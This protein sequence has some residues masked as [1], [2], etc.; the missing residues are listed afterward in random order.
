[1]KKLFFSLLLTVLC[2]AG[3][4]AQ[5]VTSEPPII[6][7]S[8]TGIVLT[9][10]PDSPES[11]Q[12]LANL[13]ASE[14][15]YAHI[16]LI[17]D[18]STGLSDWKYATTWL[19]NSDKYKLTYVSANTYTLA[20]GDLHSY[21]TA[22][23]AGEKVQKIALV[24]RNATASK[25]G[26]TASGG[27]IFVDVYDDGF[28]MA[29][30]STVSDGV[31]QVGS[32]ANFTVAATESSTL[33][34][35]ING[36][37]V[38]TAS[39]VTQLKYTHNFTAGGT[40][41]F[42]ATATNAAGTTL[43]KSMTVTAPDP[44]AQVDYPGGVPH[45]GPVANADGSVTFCLA[46]PEKSQVILVPS[47]DDYAV[48]DKNVMAYQDYEGYRYFWITVKGLDPATPYPYY[49]LVDGKTKV[50]DPYARLVLDPYNDKYISSTVWPERP[51]Y[52]YDRFSDVMLAV[53]QGN[54]ENDFKFSDFTIPDHHSLVIY[55]M[56]FRD[57]TGTEGRANANGTVRAAIE[58][59]PYLV[60][61]GVNAVELMPIMEFNGNNS[62]GYNTNFYFAPDKAYGSPR[63]YK[64]F[65]E[66]CHRNGIAVILDIVFNQSD[67][68]HPWYQMYNIASN[69]FYN[70]VAPH[71]YSVLNDWKQDNPLVQQQW[72]DALRYW[73]TV[74]N[75]DGFRF[76]LVKGLG[77]N[78]SYGGGTE[79]LNRSRIERMKHLHAVISSVKA[80]GIHINENLAGASEETQMGNDGQLQWA[81]FSNNSIQFAIGESE[82]GN[83]GRLNQ[84]YKNYGRPSG[85][86]IAYAESH[87]EERVGY[88]ISKNAP[89]G[90]RNSTYASR[91]LAMLA[92][93]FLLTPGPK[94]IWQFGELGANQTT[95]NSNGGNNTSP[96]RVIWSN[97]D[98]PDYAALHDAYRTML[99][100]RRDNPE[101]FDASTTYTIRNL[102]GSMT[103][104]RSI[105]LCNG[106]KEVVAFINANTSGD[107][108]EFS[109]ATSLL[110]ESNAQLLYA[111]PD[112]TPTLTGSGTVNVTLPANSMAIY[113]TK[114]V[115][116]NDDV[117]ADDVAAP[118]VTVR[119]GAGCI[120][121][122][123]EYTE[124]AA[125]TLD[126]RSVSTLDNLTAGIYI[127]RV[128]N[129]T[130]KVAV[131]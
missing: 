85:S 108:K 126:G 61:L 113:A 12:A 57:F 120:T 69:P 129:S 52:P 8:S 2:A 4:S 60:D 97:L 72:D 40:F 1:M 115:L 94:M 47:W 6:T 36:T 65:V 11:N 119:G 86:Y 42:E 88:R 48:L 121:V 37:Q 24:F 82:N 62:W 59:I 49:F 66:E 29:F 106:G 43:T 70:A 93:H 78:N 74:Y 99:C 80:N 98:N 123:G 127:V 44:S 27:D 26:K 33:T 35:K 39:N 118:A 31:V 34:L 46:A 83:G 30:T 21:F 28:N 53:Y 50:G 110:S 71:D 95:K 124:A 117:V 25:E 5:V 9:Y 38:T 56:L 111:S 122:S 22:L 77:D 41:L 112:V 128:D 92:A 101:L 84:L 13:S 73:M 19:D 103:L 91:R 79:A 100:L 55:E 64:E 16:G 89:E 87:D 96:K 17:T 45:M 81:N 18:K 23:P 75:V 58:K 14:A 90:M 54:L 116:G 131:K 51:A 104:P 3:L 107:D 15:V 32:S 63:D 67:G 76:D 130:F 10:H 7:Q 68:L 105:V 20:I 125:Y 102:G 114:S 109:V